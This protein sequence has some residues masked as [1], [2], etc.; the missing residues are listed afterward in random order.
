MARPVPRT[1]ARETEQPCKLGCVFI[2]G[3]RQGEPRP[4]ILTGPHK[5]YCHACVARMDRQA[6][7][8]PTWR[9]MWSAVYES[10]SAGLA[11]VTK[12]E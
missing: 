3:D 12:R 10:R 1:R 9:R 8:S 6:H 2:I 11:L 7:E 5:G 4:A